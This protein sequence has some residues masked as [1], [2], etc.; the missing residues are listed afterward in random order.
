MVD[1]SADITW[2]S[3]SFLVVFGHAFFD[4]LSVCV[5]IN[6]SA[7]RQKMK[8]HE[9]QRDAHRQLHLGHKPRTTYGDVL[10]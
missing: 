6:L 10:P 7:L 9:S 2:I 8:K 3:I 5:H 4:S 1:R